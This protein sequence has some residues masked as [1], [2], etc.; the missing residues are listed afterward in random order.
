[1]KQKTVHAKRPDDA[2]VINPNIKRETCANCGDDIEQEC[3]KGLWSH[4]S[5]NRYNCIMPVPI[6]VYLKRKFAKGEYQCKSHNYQKKEFSDAV[7]CTECG[8]SM[9]KRDF[10]TNRNIYWCRLCNFKFTNLKYHKKKFHHN[11]EVAMDYIDYSPDS[12]FEEKEIHYEDKKR[13]WSDTGHSCSHQIDIWY[14]GS[15]HGFDGDF[16]N[17]GFISKSKFLKILAEKMNV[18]S[19]D[20][21]RDRSGDSAGNNFKLISPDDKDKILYVDDLRDEVILK[22]DLEGK[23]LWIHPKLTKRQ[24]KELKQEF[25]RR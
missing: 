7:V 8:D 10:F 13:I 17:Y 4:G 6:T 19:F 22:F 5:W 2:F 3:I 9:F 14:N 25:R 21:L 11:G 16:I 1:M 12:D 23:L 20:W 18:G 24:K 15:H